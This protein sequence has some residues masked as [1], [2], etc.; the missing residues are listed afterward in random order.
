MRQISVT[1]HVRF[2]DGKDGKRRVRPGRLTAAQ[3]TGIDGENTVDNLKIFAI[4]LGKQI[5]LWQKMRASTAE[6]KYP[7]TMAIGNGWRVK[8]LLWTP[9][10]GD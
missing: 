5:L 9:H 4:T 7:A 3:M 6:L 8:R 1:F 2:G 10:S